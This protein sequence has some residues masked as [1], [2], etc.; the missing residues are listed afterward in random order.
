MI[1]T[2]RMCVWP[3]RLEIGRCVLVSVHHRRRE[4]LLFS[5][6]PPGRWQFQGLSPRRRFWPVLE[7]LVL[8]PSA[9]KAGRS[10]WV[11]QPWVCR[12]VARSELCLPPGGRGRSW[13]VWSWQ[14]WAWQPWGCR[15]EAR[16][17]AEAWHWP[18]PEEMGVAVLMQWV[19][20]WSWPPCCAQL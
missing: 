3:A 14:L 1:Y 17:A 6:R 13:W 12:S 18:A 5:A 2:V 16:S 15:S 9:G 7:L 10:W 4:C 20:S 11:W 19:W 8:A